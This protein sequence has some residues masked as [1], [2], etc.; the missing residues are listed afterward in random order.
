MRSAALV[1]ALLQPLPVTSA[2]VFG[3]A[4]GSVTL[5]WVLPDDPAVAGVTVIR[6]RLDVVEPDADFD[7]GLSSS[8]TDFNTVGGA[9]YRYGIYDR[10]AL[11]ERSDAVFVQIV[12]PVPVVFVNTTTSGSGFICV[13]SAGGQASLWPVLLAAA[14]LLLT[15]RGKQQA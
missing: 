1:L 15:L 7:L 5:T 8:F 9:S 13:A 14:L 3:N 6:Q 2:V 10:N 4:D 11:G 12:A